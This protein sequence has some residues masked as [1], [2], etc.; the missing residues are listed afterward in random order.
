MSAFDPKRTSSMSQ[1]CRFGHSSGPKWFLKVVNRLDNPKSK[2]VTFEPNHSGQYSVMGWFLIRK[3]FC[4]YATLIAFLI[5]SV[6]SFGHSHLEHIGTQSVVAGLVSTADF[7]QGRRPRSLR[8]RLARTRG[9][10]LRY[11]RHS[12]PGLLCADFN[13]AS[14][15]DPIC[16][17][18]G[19]TSDFSRNRTSTAATR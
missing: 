16:I 3:K 8:W 19:R 10:C 5:Q 15:A 9:L 6:A 13:P 1:T 2:I 12:H 14:I 17:P 4:A 7:R 18:R 11:M